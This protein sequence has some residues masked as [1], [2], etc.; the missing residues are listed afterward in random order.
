LRCFSA[1]NEEEEKPA[2]AEKGS[3]KFTYNFTEDDIKGSRRGTGGLMMMAFT[4]TK[5]DTHQAKTFSKKSYETG[6]VLINCKGCENLHLIADN[7]GW[8]RDEGVNIEQLMREKGQQV[9]KAITE[10]GDIELNLN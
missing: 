6:V 8:F 2:E 9:H 7:L 1:T 3:K 4:C 5:C 10:E